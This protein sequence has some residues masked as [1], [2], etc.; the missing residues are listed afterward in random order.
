MFITQARLGEM[1]CSPASRTIRHEPLRGSGDAL[2]LAQASDGKKQPCP[3]CGRAVSTSVRKPDNVFAA[4]VWRRHFSPKGEAFV[5][6]AINDARE[7]A[8]R[9]GTVTEARVRVGTATVHIG[10]VP[11]D[12]EEWVVCELPDGSKTSV[13]VS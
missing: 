5:A 2:L 1:F 6:E 13:R 10:Y 11:P 7:I 3:T 4:I 12:G 9:S 8:T